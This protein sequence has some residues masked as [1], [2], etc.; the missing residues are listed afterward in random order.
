MSALGMGYVPV[1]PGAETCDDYSETYVCTRPK[2]HGGR[3][4]GG[5]WAA[6]DKTQTVLDVWGEDVHKAAR[7]RGRTG[8][9]A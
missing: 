8:G 6:S 1:I 9:A 3:H 2:G 4:A 5:Y 7:E